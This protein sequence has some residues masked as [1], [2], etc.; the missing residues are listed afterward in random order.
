MDANIPKLVLLVTRINHIR[1][2]ALVDVCMSEMNGYVGQ[3]G[4]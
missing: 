1:R 4:C 2:Y 3:A